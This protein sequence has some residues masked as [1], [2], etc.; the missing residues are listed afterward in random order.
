MCATPAPNTCARIMAAMVIPIRIG[1]MLL[2]ELLSG[3]A[4][5]NPD[6]DPHS[7]LWKEVNKRSNE[8]DW[9]RA[10]IRNSGDHLVLKITCHYLVC[11]LNFR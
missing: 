11:D 1:D 9:N 2:S 3:G 10:K 7:L 4:D 6:E 5:E 8:E